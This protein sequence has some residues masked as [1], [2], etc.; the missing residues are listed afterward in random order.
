ME[1]LR[2]IMTSTFYPPFHLG[3]DAV[4]VKYLAEELAARGHEVHVL[5]SRDAYRL[6]RKGEP[7]QTDNGGVHVHALDSPYGRL[8][9]VKAYA[10]G[11]S[12]FIMNQY[13]KLV[14]EV[15]PD[16]VHHHN[17]SL[18][19]HDLLKKLGD[20]RQLYTLHD[21]WL[22]CQQGNLMKKGKQCDGNGCF[23]CAISN[24][25]PP[26]CWRN[27]LYLGDIDCLISPSRFVANSLS[28]LNIPTIVLPNFSPEPPVNIPDISEENFYLYIGIIDSFKGIKTLLEAFRKS[29]NRLILIGNGP[30]SGMTEKYIKKENLSPR[31]KFLGWKSDEKW[32]Y[33]KKANALIIPSLVPENCPLIALEAMSVGTPVICSDVGGTGEVVSK[34]SRDMVIPL[35][36]LLE[37]LKDIEMPSISR[38]SVSKIF[39]D[40]FSTEK[41]LDAY[42]KIIESGC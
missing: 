14:D 11:N 35:N 31:V 27:K 22:V 7:K 2:F 15:K 4:H 30:M 20:Y 5:Y 21:R 19:G 40:N 3:G 1:T 36:E 24:L 28:R 42:L 34:L 12:S 10:F 26:Q 6:K 29:N 39:R 25:K 17:I 18:L 41:Y 16:V 37:K 38:E 23:L 32:S 9:P 33:L 13:R 8:T